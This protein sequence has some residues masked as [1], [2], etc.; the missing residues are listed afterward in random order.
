MLSSR[1][2]TDER[3]GRE[4]GALFY[5]MFPPRKRPEISF[6]FQEETKY[7]QIPKEAACGWAGVLT[8]CCH[9]VGRSETQRVTTW[10]SNQYRLGIHDTPSPRLYPGRYKGVD[11]EAPCPEELATGHWVRQDCKQVRMYPGREPQSGMLTSSA[12]ED[13]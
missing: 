2:H 4:H 13:I 7:S 3:V 6:S 8:K 10:P 12:W 5:E 9:P 11:V 1:K